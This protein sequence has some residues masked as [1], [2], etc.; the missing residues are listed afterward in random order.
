[1]TTG[2]VRAATDGREPQAEG[3]WEAEASDVQ[4][5]EKALEALRKQYASPAAA[6]E[7][8]A[9]TRNSVAN[10]VIYAGSEEDAAQAT[11]AVA[12]LAGRHPSRTILLIADLEPGTPEVRASVSAHCRL[13]GDG[14]RICYEEIRLRAAG[15]SGPHLRSIIDP[16]LISDL[17]V[18]LWWTGDPPVRDAVFQTL[19]APADRLLIDSG[20]FRSPTPTLTRLGQFVEDEAIGVRVGDLNWNR[21]TSWREILAQLFDPP[22]TADLLPAVRRVRIERAAAAGGA[23]ASPAQSLLLAGWLAARLDWEPGVPGER[24]FG[25]ADRLRL[26]SRGKD[27]LVELREEP[28]EGASPGDVQSLQ[29]QAE[30]GEHTATLTITRAADQEH[31]WTRVTID[32]GPAQERSVRLPAPEDAVLLG[33]EIEQL[34]PDRV[35]EETAEMAGRLAALVRPRGNGDRRA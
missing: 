33:E 3:S 6:R 13:S 9:G 16:L 29:I 32:E 19:A 20:H 18:F 23:P 25:G 1:V 7:G 24:T 10:L 17:P 35:F 30:D 4:G 8:Q 14:R 27:V 31:A 11:T 22:A 26:R 28:H 2:A 12:Q 15:R 21:L 34:D 5:I